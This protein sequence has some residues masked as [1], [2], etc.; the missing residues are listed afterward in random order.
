MHA[1]EYLPNVKVS[2]NFVDVILQM[3]KNSKPNIN[4]LTHEEKELL[5]TL[6]HLYILVRGWGSAPQL[7]GVVVALL[8][9]FS[10]YLWATRC[11]QVG[12]TPILHGLWLECIASLPRLCRTG[13]RSCPGRGAKAVESRPRP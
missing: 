10:I 6:L 7:F 4:I 3:C 1:I 8:C 9:F 13:T 2:D 5:D 12:F 11:N